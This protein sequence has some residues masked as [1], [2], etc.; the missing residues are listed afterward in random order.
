LLAPS[1]G[2]DVTN[3]KRSQFMVSDFE[4]ELSLGSL[5]EFEPSPGS[6]SASKVNQ[7]M[8][9]VIH[10]LIFFSGLE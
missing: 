5:D 6:E 8:S 2:L 10:P 1:E 3:A 7:L 9:Q 4:S